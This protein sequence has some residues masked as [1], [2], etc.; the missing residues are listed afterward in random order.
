MEIEI[1]GIVGWIN[2]DD[3]LVSLEEFHLNYKHQ[4]LGG[5]NC[6]LDESEK[7]NGK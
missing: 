7:K 3:L 5:A 4:I 1:C 6:V 2:I